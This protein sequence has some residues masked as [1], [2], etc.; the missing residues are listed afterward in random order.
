M[1]F[2]FRLDWPFL[3]PETALVSIFSSKIVVFS[4]K[5]FFTIFVDPYLSELQR[6][7]NDYSTFFVWLFYFGDSNLFRI[8]C[9]RLV[10][11]RA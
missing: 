8:S 2:L 11:V 1:E 7:L 6:D 10:R 5:K 9:F 4:G 3:R